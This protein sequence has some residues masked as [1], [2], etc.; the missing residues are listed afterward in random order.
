MAAF[1][2]GVGSEQMISLLV[3]SAG[4]RSGSGIGSWTVG[5]TSQGQ[6]TAV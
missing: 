1:A 5:R 4:I 3:D 2:L 6:R